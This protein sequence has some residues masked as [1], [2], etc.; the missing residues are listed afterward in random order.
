MTGPDDAQFLADFAT[1][2]EFG[3]TGNGGVERQAASEAD[4]EQRAWMAAL[5]EKYGAKVE[6]DEVGNQI[7]RFELRPDAPYVLVGS[8]LDSQPTAGKYDG[9]YGVLAGAHAAARLTARWREEGHTP[10]YNLAVVNWFNEEGSRFKPSMMGSGVFTG[11]LDAGEVLAIEDVRGVSVRNALDRL[12]QRGSAAQP[13][14]AAYAEIHVEQG[15]GLEKDGLTIGVV[16]A[17]WGAN[18]YVITVSGEQGHT[19]ATLMPD[20]RDALLGASLLVVA[21]REI[22]DELADGPLQTSVGQMLIYP[23]SPV[24]VAS[25]VTLL[26]D[27]RSPDADVL[28]QAD[29]L[30]Q[31]RIAEIEV[32]AD[33]EVHLGTSHRWGVQ[34][35]TDSGIALAE[36]V[37]D[38]LGLKHGRTMT[39]AGHDSTNMKDVVP[40][41]FL[42]VPSVD[43]VSHNEAELTHDEDM[44]DGLAMLTETVRRMCDGAL[45]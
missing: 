1:L 2:S 41:V 14:V 24:V 42:F 44:L 22:A 31:Q 5:L 17:T 36:Q 15:K 4:G 35:Y 3:A 37:A 6:Y 34:P 29:R 18:K 21:A 13:N 43:G 7:G 32:K 10:A 27:L 19:G 39:L 28:A 12:G 33:V 45:G 9:A 26:L 11:K 8:H 38:D 40:T 30:L 25:E 23:N 20:R 16:E